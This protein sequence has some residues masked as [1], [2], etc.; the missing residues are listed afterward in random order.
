MTEAEMAQ[1]WVAN[2]DWLIRDHVRAA[3]ESAA[4]FGT[5]QNSLSN[6]RNYVRHSAEAD[7]LAVRRHS[8]G[9]LYGHG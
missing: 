9:S 2:I 4:L 8:L 6:I 3:L 7:R 5:E 1:A